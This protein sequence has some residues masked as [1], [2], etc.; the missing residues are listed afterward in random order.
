MPTKGVKLLKPL[1]G[2]V[3]VPKKRFPQEV[4]LGRASPGR[5]VSN[6]GQYLIKPINDQNTGFEM[7]N[8][9]PKVISQVNKQYLRMG[10]LPPSLQPKYLRKP[11]VMDQGRAAAISKGFRKPRS[12]QG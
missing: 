5:P 10:Q 11:E 6:I 3:K 1:S 9:E 2:G 7:L 8:T 4:P 12:H